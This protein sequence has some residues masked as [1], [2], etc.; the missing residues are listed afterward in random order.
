MNPGAIGLGNGLGAGNEDCVDCRTARM[1]PSYL[2]RAHSDLS[3]LHQRIHIS[4][5][6]SSLGPASY[7]DER[8][9]KQMLILSSR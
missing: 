5:S 6:G 7:P 9:N 2:T 1:P 3:K 8:R 4:R